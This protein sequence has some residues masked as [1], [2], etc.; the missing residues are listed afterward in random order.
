MEMSQKIR[1]A[2]FVFDGVPVF[3]LAAPQ[4]VFDEVARQ[5][6]AEWECRL[7]SLHGGAV[8]SA[9]GYGISHVEPLA[10]AATADIVVMPSW[11]DDARLIDPPTRAILEA[12]RNRGA[13]IAG[14]CLGALPV[15]DTGILD[16][17]RVTTHWKAIGELKRR[18]P[19]VIA[20]GSVLYIDHGDVLTSAGTASSMDACLHIVRDRLGATAANSVARALVLAPHRGGSQAQFIE[21]PVPPRAG[22]APLSELM[23]WALVNLDQPLGIDELAARAHLSRRTFI[24]QFHLS[25]GTTPAAWVRARRLDEARRLLEETSLSMDVVAERSGF[26]TAVTLRQ[27]FAT[28]FATSPSEYRRRFSAIPG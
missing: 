26:S 28:A 24:R 20:D 11:H 21:R 25:T 15:A 4:T 7:F 2:V 3:H 14:L 10:Y 19:A 18:R 23:E 12:A 17:R 9:E 27:N 13:V 1:I 16:G 8:T 22:Q 6:F 5:G